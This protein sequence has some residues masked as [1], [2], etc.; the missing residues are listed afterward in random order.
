MAHTEAMLIQD[1]PGIRHV[2]GGF[3]SDDGRNVMK[4]T[5][6]KAI[7]LHRELWDWLYHHPNK[8]KWDWPSWES[9][10]GNIPRVSSYCFLCEYS[11]QHWNN[12]CRETCILDWSPDSGCLGDGA[13]ERWDNAISPRTRKKYAKIIRDL[14]ERQ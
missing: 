14:P 7:E 12:Y 1:A 4:L 6:K 13:F 5:K 8:Q 11:V 10:G 9:N 2:P 3:V